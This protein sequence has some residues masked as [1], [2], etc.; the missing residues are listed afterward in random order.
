MCLYFIL[1][2]YILICLYVK[3]N[4]YIIVFKYLYIFYSKNENK[5]AFNY[6]HL[7]YV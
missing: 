3:I 1:I 4:G 2:L 7:Y 5:S 6:N